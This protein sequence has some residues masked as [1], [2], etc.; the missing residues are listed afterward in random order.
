MT[1]APR[2]VVDESA[3]DPGA[4]I[5]FAEPAG[6]TAIPLAALLNLPDAP[7]VDGL[8]AALGPLLETAPDG[9]T[10]ERFVAQLGAAQQMLAALCEIG[11]VHCSIGLHRDDVA[12]AGA[13][14]G[15]GGG[16]PLLSFF[17]LSWRDTAVAPPAVTAARAVTPAEHH[18]RIECLELPCGPATL[19]ESVRTPTEASGLPPEPLLQIHAHLPH[20]DGRRLVVLVMSTTAVERRDDYRRLLHQIAELV[21][22]DNPLDEA[23]AS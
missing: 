5:W 8:R 14:G 10:R 18:T 7:G 13:V 2:F 3:G 6:F 17:T 22:F 23:A 21:S 15:E 4:D 16:R 19:S 9:T 12:G 11:T 20:P 1:A